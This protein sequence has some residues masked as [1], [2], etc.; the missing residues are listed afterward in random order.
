MTDLGSFS[1][2]R[3]VI[4]D[5][6][7]EQVDAVTRIFTIAGA[8]RGNHYHRETV[9]WTYVL[10][11]RLLVASGEDRATLA[12]GDL[13]VDLPG[14]PHAWKALEDTDVLVFTRGPRSGTDYERDT[15]RLETPLIVPESFEAQRERI[16][17]G[18]ARESDWNVL[19]HME[20]QDWWQGPD[21]TP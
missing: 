13:A 15:F 2:E 16:G 11:G 1:D 18:D 17:N 21:R 19:A 8:V 3:G 12:P 20:H 10:T 4:Q 7:M 14:V 5:L 9:Q 6:L